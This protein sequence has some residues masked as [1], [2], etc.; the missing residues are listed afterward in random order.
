MTALCTYRIKTGK[1]NDFI[2]LLRKHWPTLH[3][4]GLVADNPSQIFQGKDDSGGTFFV[5]V[6]TWKDDESPRLAHELPAVM[7]VWE[8]MGMCCEERM[9]RPAMEFPEVKPLALHG[10]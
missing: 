7:S 5:E 1:E 9:G 8:P 10:A 3:E 6:L 2:A 4:Q